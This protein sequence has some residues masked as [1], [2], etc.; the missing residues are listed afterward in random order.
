MYMETRLTPIPSQ[1]TSEEWFLVTNVSN[2][3]QLLHTRPADKWIPCLRQHEQRNLQNKHTLDRF[4]LKDVSKCEVRA[5][6]QL[7]ETN[8]P[9]IIQVPDLAVASG[10]CNWDQKQVPYSNR[11]SFSVNVYRTFSSTVY[12]FYCILR[13]SPFWTKPTD[14]LSWW[15]LCRE[16][17]RNGGGGGEKYPAVYTRT[18]SFHDLTKPSFKITLPRT[19][20]ISCTLSNYY[21]TVHDKQ[22]WQ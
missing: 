14:L 20:Y 11:S 5:E 21:H 4:D 6:I 2:S 18:P 22:T 16:P 7:L 17:Q 8:H 15:V 1:C 3:K 13:G 19:P 12:S 9:K 10:I